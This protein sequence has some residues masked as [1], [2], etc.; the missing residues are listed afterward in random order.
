MGF[1]YFKRSLASPFH[2]KLV[3]ALSRRDF[4]PVATWRNGYLTAQLH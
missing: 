4:L 1:M 3:D 2:L